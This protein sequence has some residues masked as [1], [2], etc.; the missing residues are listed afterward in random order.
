MSGMLALLRKQ[1]TESRWMLGISSLALFAFGWLGVFLVS[2]GQS[3]FRRQSG[4]RGAFTRAMAGEGAAITTGVIEMSF[5]LHPFIWGPVV[6]WAI[7]RGSL[8]VAGELERGTLDLTLSRPVRRS[9]YLASQILTAGLGLALMVGSLLAG[10][11]IGTR[12]NAI[13]SPPEML[14]LMRP[15][16]NLAALGFCVFGYTLIVS[17]LDTVRWRPTLVGSALTIAGFAAWVVSLAPV[18]RDTSWQ[19]CLSRCSVFTAFNPVEAIGKAESLALHLV[20]L[21]GVG[22]AGVVL[23]LIGFGTRDLPSSA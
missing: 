7:G 11:L 15:A 4:G 22:L 12:F 23:G 14:A 19:T 10:N 20:I 2:L 9:T 3:E 1:L 16:V 18:L 17:A 8:S 5:W 6:V 21:G 13:E